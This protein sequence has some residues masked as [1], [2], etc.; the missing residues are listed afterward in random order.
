MSTVVTVPPKPNVQQLMSRVNDRTL[1]FA[2]RLTSVGDVM[3]STAPQMMAA[4]P[5]HVTADRM[6]RVALNAIRK[7]PKLLDCSAASLFAAITEAATY[8]WEIGGVL[9]HAYLVPFKDEC[10]LIPGYKGLIDLCR[11]SGQVSTISLEAVYEGDVFTHTLGD[12]PKIDHFPN[13]ADPQRT[14][15]QITHVYAVVR[16]RDGGIQR[17]VWSRAKVEA[18]KEQYSQAWRRAETSGKKDSFWHTAWEAAAKKTVMREMI[19]R[20]LLPVSAEY[21]DLV[22]R[23]IDHDDGE[24]TGMTVDVLPPEPLP[25]IE[26]A[27]I[28]S[29]PELPPV[30]DQTPVSAAEPAALPNPA[31]LAG[32]AAD[33]D[34]ASTLLNVEAIQKHWLTAAAVTEADKAAITARCEA[35]A[36]EIRGGRGE[37]S[38]Q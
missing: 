24:L 9:G 34:Q 21:Q 17:S 10:Q 25:A 33:L 38:N 18:H 7:N 36:A 3:R 11:R 20:G 19:N 37:R 15:R 28:I 27:A 16:L 6:I 8:G 26:Q 22:K 23:G 14:L 12:E 35:K 13:E 31:L 32:V 1:S 30:A 2:A 29:P 5:K 4:L